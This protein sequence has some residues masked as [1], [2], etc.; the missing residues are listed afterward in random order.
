MIEKIEEVLTER[1]KRKQSI[2]NCEGKVH[3]NGLYKARDLSLVANKKGKLNKNIKPYQLERIKS[4]KD[5]S[6]TS[7]DPLFID[8]KPDESIVFKQKQRNR[9]DRTNRTKRQDNPKQPEPKEER[10]SSRKRTRQRSKY[11]QEGADDEKQPIEVDKEITKEDID[12]SEPSIKKSPKKTDQQT[13][14]LKSYTQNPSKELKLILRSPKSNQRSKHD[15]KL[16]S[17]GKKRTDQKFS[18]SEFS[19]I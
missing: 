18:S 15:S 5:I 4:L 9:K 19:D 16:K 11:S 13:N 1:R 6:P 17:G 10:K 2:P 8:S 14:Q 12:G 7:K 3:V